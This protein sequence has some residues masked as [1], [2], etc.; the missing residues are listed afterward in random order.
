MNKL[1]NHSMVNSI[2]S[3]SNGL[4]MQELENGNGP[5][6]KPIYKKSLDLT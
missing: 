2:S 5:Y 4:H 6:R 1:L 3:S